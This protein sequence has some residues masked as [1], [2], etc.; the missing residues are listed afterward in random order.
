MRNLSLALVGAFCAGA[1]NA[2]IIDF[3]VDAANNPLVNGKL[4]DTEFQPLFT[5]S[6]ADR[7]SGNTNDGAVIF[8]TTSGVNPADPDLHVNLGNALAL[9]E[10]GVGTVSNDVVSPV[11]DSLGGGF[12]YFDFASPIEPLSVALLDINGGNR[13]L[14]SLIDSLGNT[15]TYD[16]PAMWTFDISA[17]GNPPGALGWGTLDLTTLAPQPGENQG[18]AVV[19]FNDPGFNGADV[20]RVEYDFRGSGAIDNFEFVPEPSS[21]LLL[22]FAG[23]VARRR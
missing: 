22:A 13:I 20:V 19:T 15:R 12:I 1:A 6:S 3:S 14:L 8:D 2:A 11:N 21:L 23:L 7:G 18:N 16:V 17:G 4:I 9:Q 5:V 10:A